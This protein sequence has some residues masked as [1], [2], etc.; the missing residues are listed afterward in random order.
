MYVY[1]IY[2]YMGHIGHVHPFLSIFHIW[3]WI[4]IRYPNHWMV[5]T[6]NTKLDIHI[7]GPTSVF[8]FDPHP[9]VA[10]SQRVSKT[11]TAS[12]KMVKMQCEPGAAELWNS[13]C[14]MG[15]SENGVYPQ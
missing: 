12:M 4:K 8:H 15:M 13:T 14:D 5:N 7:C 10:G 9:Y 6:L 11:T 1:N 3:V 2:I